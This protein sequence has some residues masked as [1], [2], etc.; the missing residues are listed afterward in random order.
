M[1]CPQRECHQHAGESCTS[2]NDGAQHLQ[3]RCA[4]IRSFSEALLDGRRM[5]AE[6]RPN[7]QAGCN[8]RSNPA[9]EAFQRQIS[10]SAKSQ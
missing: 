9:A 5:A 7:L 3:Q 1:T 4:E 8:K 6:D 2:Y 10:A